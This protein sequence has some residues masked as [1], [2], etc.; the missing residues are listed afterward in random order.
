M[1]DKSKDQ[2]LGK[3]IEQGYLDSA[4]EQ[5]PELAEQWAAH[6]KVES[7]FANLRGAAASEE[8][9]QEAPL[10]SE[11]GPYQ[12]QELL[13]QGTFGNV[14]LGYDAKLER[15]VAIK[16][17]RQSLLAESSND[18]FLRE[19]RTA[20]QLNHPNIV[21]VFEVAQ[22]EDRTYIVSD[23]IDGV[24]MDQWRKDE[25]LKAD[26]AAKL[27]LTIAAAVAHA[28]EQ[29]VIHRDLKPS[30]IMMD[31]L[32]N[33]FVMDFGLAKRQSTDAT[34][35][36]EGKILG[37]PA[38]MSPE[39]ARGDN[40]EVDARADVYALGVILFELLT[41]ERPFRGS[42]QMLL[43]QVI[44]ED[45][46]DPRKLNS[47]VPRDLS[48]ICLK[49]LEKSPDGRYSSVN[50]FA[51]DITRYLEKRPIT[52]RPLG[53]VGRTLRWC[54]RRP[55]VAGLSTAVVISL[56]AGTSISL[57]Y[58]ITADQERVI[59]NKQRLAAEA[60][61]D[62]EIEQRKIAVKQKET[63]DRNFKMAM[64]AID[65]L[66]NVSEDD[67]FDIPKMEPVRRDLLEKVKAFYE[68]FVAQ[69]VEEPSLIR[70][71]AFAYYKLGLIEMDLGAHPSAEA[72]YNRS[73]EIYTQLVK[74]PTGG[75]GDRKNLAHVYSSLAVILDKT[76]KSNEAAA[77]CRKAISIAEQLV[78]DS[79]DS[80][81]TNHLLSG[82]YDYLGQIYKR[83]NNADEAISLFRKAMSIREDLVKVNPDYLLNWQRLSLSYSNLAATLDNEEDAQSIKLYNK[84]IEV[85]NERVQNDFGNI[86][87]AGLYYNLGVIRN[88]NG[89]TNEAIELHSKA[90]VM[91]EQLV[92]DHPDIPKRAFD[93]ANFHGSIANSLKTLERTDQAVKAYSRAIQI[94]EKLVNDESDVPTYAFALALSYTNLG[95][96]HQYSTGRLDE[97]VILYRKAI[98]IAER[99][100]KFHPNHMVDSELHLKL[101]YYLAHALHRSQKATEA[102]DLFNKLAQW[103]YSNETASISS[104]TF[105]MIGETIANLKVPDDQ[106]AKY[107]R[108]AVAIKESLVRD[109]P[110][111]VKYKED[112]AVA[113]YRLGGICNALGQPVKTSEL[114]GEAVML[115]DSLANDHPTE[116]RYAISLAFYCNKHG[117]VFLESDKTEDALG[118]FSRVTTI[119]EEVHKGNPNNQSLYDLAASYT[120]LANIMNQLE[121]TDEAIAVLCKEIIL[122]EQLVKDY[123]D[124]TEYANQLGMTQRNI[125]LAHVKLGQTSHAVEYYNKV[126]ARMEQLVK[127][128]PENPV[129]AFALAYSYTE[130]GDVFETIGQTEESR[131]LYQKAIK[132]GEQLTATYSNEPK[133]AVNLATDYY[134]YGLLLQTSESL[135]VAFKFYEKSI[136]IEEQ[137]VNRYPA[138]SDYAVNLEVSYRTIAAELYLSGD[139]TRTLEFYNKH[140]KLAAKIAELFPNI[141]SLDYIQMNRFYSVGMV[142]ILN[143]DYKKA[144]IHIDAFVRMQ[145]PKE[146]SRSAI[147]YNAACLSSVASD[148]VSND[149]DLAGNDQKALVD[150][151]AGRALE[152]LVEIR[153]LKYFDDPENI[154]HLRKDSDLAPI[155]ER[156]DFKK[157]LQELE[158]GLEN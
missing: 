136:A 36:M 19:A 7:L 111:E 8:P 142:Y 85:L 61:K 84:A 52:A 140:A 11:I 51:E 106:A 72:N 47:H 139:Q 134:N 39:Q 109:F 3:A 66:Q 152:F 34:M 17:P 138:I 119:R 95:T 79:P 120:V 2:H 48:T 74:P 44:H 151:Y 80:Y 49:C 33:P 155:R 9:E 54:R 22:E 59:A 12:I 123:P 29:G 91:Q 104:T 132:I 148:V 4:N 73:I 86:I 90:I 113:Y 127:E 135:D 43:H 92:K 96:T 56:L 156:D 23:F 102:S 115:L 10:P 128:E 26:D 62:A 88:N 122:R 145:H 107:F 24:P 31:K 130:L 114:Y 117:E 82:S 15:K 78:A 103:Y 108:K 149:G 20:A 94:A 40:S 35:T 125:G 98:P 118:L 150:K 99:L 93:L 69:A 27:C 28:H 70:K 76:G 147:Y 60:A 137:L 14:Y 41:G 133:Y 16:V 21:S 144:S 154:V 37:T 46:P 64:N 68:E 97:A 157:F 65:E 116:Q 42:T 5:S 63:A 126:T 89:Q 55:L 57:Y 83:Q 105:A 13:G 32:D 87:L 77:L 143:G 67:L 30:N 75:P 50:D 158:D 81:S 101:Y 6:Q 141:P 124:V 112:L 100:V 146:F 153:S 110:D 1:N 45:A 58:G 25:P 121:R 131:G 129:H 38:Y 18:Q 53:R 71:L